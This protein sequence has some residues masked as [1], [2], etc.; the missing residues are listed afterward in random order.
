MTEEHPLPAPSANDHDRDE[1]GATLLRRTLL[2]ALGVS[3]IGGL[4]AGVL[5]L[6]GRAAV[7]RDITPSPTAVPTHTAV[8][9]TVAAA[10]PSASPAMDH[11]ALAEAA[12]K[13]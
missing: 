7:A 5:G 13:A 10:S 4:T 11:D 2:S 6:T 1:P 9:T 12:V 3:A 8:H